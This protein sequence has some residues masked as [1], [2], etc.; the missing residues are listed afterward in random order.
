LAESGKSAAVVY[1]VKS[2]YAEKRIIGILACLFI[3]SLLIVHAQNKRVP[4]T[5][6]KVILWADW[7]CFSLHYPKT[8][9][10][11]VVHAALR[12][13]G[14]GV[15][16]WGDRSFAYDLN[17]DHKPEYFIPLVCGAVG[18]C[19]W[20]AF[21]L[22]PSRL[23]G[24]M[25]GENIYVR[26]RVKRWSALTVYT[27]NSCCDGFLDTYIFRQGKYAKLPGGYYVT[28]SYGR[29]GLP[30]FKAHPFPRFMETTSSPCTSKKINPAA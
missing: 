24:L 6:A 30:G 2:S 21:A 22:N 26:Q 3:A 17:G 7:D 19:V 28:A 23:L 9:L 27:H 15:K 25:N 18:N 16:I 13:A 4:E 14:D 20:G 11:R 12:K 29:Y 5:K 1:Q 10:K 8:K